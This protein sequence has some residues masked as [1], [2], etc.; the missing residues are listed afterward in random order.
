MIEIYLRS[1]Q[2]FVFFIFVLIQ[3]GHGIPDRN[4]KNLLILRN[5]KNLCLV[6]FPVIFPL[7]MY[8]FKK[9]CSNLARECEITDSNRKRLDKSQTRSNFLHLIG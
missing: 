7:L 6:F 9:T 3:R 5:I 4:T 2:D 8:V 1:F